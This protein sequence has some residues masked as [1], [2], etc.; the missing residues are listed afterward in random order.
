MR[1]VRRGGGGIRW[2]LE[3]IS[4]IVGVQEADE[5][6]EKPQTIIAVA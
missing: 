4:D 5:A 6:I 1:M 2:G 3:G